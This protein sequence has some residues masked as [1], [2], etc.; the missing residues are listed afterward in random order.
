[1]RSPHQYLKCRFLN[2]TA[3]KYTC[4]IQPSSSCGVWLFFSFCL[5]QT[6][7]S[8]RYE[9][10]ISKEHRNSAQLRQGQEE[11]EDFSP[12]FLCS[13]LCPGLCALWKLENNALFCSECPAERLK[14][15]GQKKKKKKRKA[16]SV[17]S[18]NYTQRQ[19]GESLN[20]QRGKVSSTFRK[21]ATYS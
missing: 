10:I 16:T 18:G 12:P 13:Y 14:T 7:Q 15:S 9:A 8:G 21:R 11:L 3:S 1:M 5:P 4:K 17:V 6:K 2:S 20:T 19:L